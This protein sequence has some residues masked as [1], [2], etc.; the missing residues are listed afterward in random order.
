MNQQ[1]TTQ[2]L[3]VSERK[4][5]FSRVQNNFRFFFAIIFPHFLRSHTTGNRRPTCL[6]AKSMRVRVSSLRSTNR[7]YVVWL[8]AAEDGNKR[9]HRRRSIDSIL[10]YN[11][12][13]SVEWLSLTSAKKEEDSQASARYNRIIGNYRTNERTNEWNNK[14][15]E[16]WR[17]S[18]LNIYQR[19]NGKCV[20]FF[21]RKRSTRTRRMNDILFSFNRFSPIS[22]R[23]GHWNWMASAII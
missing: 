16:N 7:Y 9:L 11:F 13:R 19:L 6:V 5:D 4:N 8:L 2:R 20:W 12:F 22:G 17:E 21:I 14:N 10:N 23:R 3:C 15:Q 1:P 18:F